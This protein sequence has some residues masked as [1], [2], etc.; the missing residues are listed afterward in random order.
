MYGGFVN[1]SLSI[2]GKSIYYLIKFK[3]NYNLF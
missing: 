2:V 1:T 3:F